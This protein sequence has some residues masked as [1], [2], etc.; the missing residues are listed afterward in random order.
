MPRGSG[1]RGRAFS[2][3]ESE[4]LVMA[5]RPRYGK[6]FG[7]QEEQVGV[8][9]RELEPQLGN[10]VRRQEEEIGALGACPG[11]GSKESPEAGRGRNTEGGSRRRPE[12]ARS[13]GVG[14]RVAETGET[15]CAF[16]KGKRR[17]E[18]RSPAA[19]VPGVETPTEQEAAEGR[20]EDDR[21]I[22]P[23]TFRRPQEQ[24]GPEETP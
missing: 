17:A 16:E 13:S 11:A 2:A 3:E 15:A 24:S 19:V 1:M 21:R 9:R 23:Q 8:C 18:H 12:E 7:S 14:V 22:G 20:T 5:V 6:L 10:G 4:A